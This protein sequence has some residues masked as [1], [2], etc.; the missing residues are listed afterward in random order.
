MTGW[1][2]FRFNLWKKATQAF[3]ALLAITPRQPIWTEQN[4]QGYAREGY[5]QNPYAYACIRQISA[6]CTGIPWTL[7][8]LKSDGSKEEILVHPL[9]DLI[10]KPNP[11]QSKNAFLEELLSH[12][13]LGGE[14]FIDIIPSG[15]PTELWLLRPD[16]MT[17]LPG[18]ITEPV[19]GY[20][21]EISGNK[22]TFP[23]E[24]ILHLKRFHPLDDWHGLSN[25]APAA[26]SE[27]KLSF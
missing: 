10:K 26:K 15:Q 18:N 9:L 23:R 12:F 20:Q 1:Q 8:E 24:Q 4:Y 5:M 25:L 13:L 22:V 6:A 11:M 21:Y 19:A 27:N 7:F 16:R 17:I 2:R 3:G 14:S